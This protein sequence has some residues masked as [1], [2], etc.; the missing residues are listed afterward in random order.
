M[1]II[2]LYVPIVCIIYNF[3]NNITENYNMDLFIIV[4]IFKSQSLL[5]YVDYKYYI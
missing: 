3:L 4:Y 2:Y 5:Y 1:K